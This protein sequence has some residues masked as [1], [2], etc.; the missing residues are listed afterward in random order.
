[1]VPIANP[2]SS[3]LRR[4]TRK[5][6]DRP[7]AQPGSVET[8]RP[9]VQ[10]LAEIGPTEHWV[11]SCYLKL[12]PRDRSRG[13]YLIKLKNRIKEQLRW[14]ERREAK[15]QVRET[16]ER[17]LQRIREYL[18]HSDN[19]PT[20]QGIAIFACEP[21]DLF[22]AVPLPRV[23]RS[24]LAVDRTPLIREL[25]ALDDEFGRIMCV[26]YD[27]ASA[28]FFEVTAFGIEESPSLAA[29]DSTR[30]G[31]FRGQQA[32]S[33]TGATSGSS[34]EHN[35]HQRIRN[36]KHRHYAAIAQ[37]LFEAS[38]GR[39]IRGVVL[40][41][42]GTGSEAVEPH[43]HPYVASQ[44][45]GSVRVNPKAVT[46]AKVL[47]AVLQTRARSERAGEA[48]HVR[49]MQEGLGTGWAVNGIDS[50]LRALGSGQVRTL[51]VEPTVERSGFRCAG[52]GRL[53]LHR[54]DCDGEGEADRVPDV[55][56]EAIEEALRQ[57]AHVEIVEDATVRSEIDG[58]AA[59][60]RF[61][62]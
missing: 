5:P 17:D 25:A 13:K 20:G 18:E 19:L 14:L 60:L 3:D 16:V 55:V 24:R 48:E 34:G 53:T 54:N 37:R 29:S 35:F 8:L 2:S 32:V 22:E 30:P 4:V 10:W 11:V 47:E 42:I 52:T 46:P 43:L 44:L 49:E 7:A 1:M 12:E 15:R 58:L 6:A 41:G 61:K 62:R 26:A 33:G 27:R 57:G 56:D 21:L 45:L 38:R 31:R 51:M 40:A 36:E 39:A 50:V 9:I 28:R 59:L 23:F